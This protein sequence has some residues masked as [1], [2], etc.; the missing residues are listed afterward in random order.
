MLLILPAQQAVAQN[1]W[2]V[3]ASF[4]ASDA[5]Y[6][7]GELVSDLASLGWTINNPSV[8]DTDTAWKAYAG[9]SFNEYVALEGGFA[10][11][12][13]VETRFGATV[14]PDEIDAILRDTY[15]IHP[16]LGDGWYGAVVLSYPV[17]PEQF[18]LTARAGFFGWESD[19]D[20]EVV[21]GGTG[22][23]S[24]RDSGTDMLYGLGVEWHVNEQW[25]ITGEW[26]R[27]ELKDWV[28][29]PSVGVKFRF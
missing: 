19:I 20:V 14:A 2:Y 22:R 23:V 27:Y 17:S 25:T 24:D 4:G 26:E 11:L 3:G 28:D 5:D 29:V 16:V 10:D 21:Q 1:Q 15:S 8:D 9:F 18:S 7:S 6:S 12:G 13:K